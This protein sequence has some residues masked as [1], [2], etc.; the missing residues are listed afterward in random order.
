MLTS[1]VPAA[2]DALLAI[3]R[4]R[5]ALAQVAIVDGPSAVNTTDKRRIHIGWSPSGESAVALQQAFNAAGART[6]DE[7]LTITGYAEAR[8][9]EKD[10][11]IARDQVFAL[12]GEIEQAL[13]ASGAEPE[14]PTLRGTVLWAHLTT[15]DLQQYVSDGSVAGVE[16]TVTCQARI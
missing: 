9:G 15:G 13:R 4:D 7:A 2:V 1:R 14:A 10:M 3:L 16:F 6:R 12:V 8:V 5:P 11:K